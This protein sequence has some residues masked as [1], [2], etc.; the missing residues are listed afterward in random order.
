MA[1]N[2]TELDVLAQDYDPKTAWSAVLL[3]IRPT[4]N[5]YEIVQ[6]LTNIPMLD[7]VMGLDIDDSGNR[8]YATG[9]DD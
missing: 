1:S 7:R 8:Y 5:G 4:T 2:G 9:V 6:T 3:H